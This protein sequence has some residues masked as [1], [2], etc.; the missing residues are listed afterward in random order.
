MIRNDVILHQNDTEREELGDE[1]CQDGLYT[2]EVYATVI[3]ITNTPKRKKI[4]ISNPLVN[5]YLH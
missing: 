3:P 2:S 4:Y 5:V 1:Q